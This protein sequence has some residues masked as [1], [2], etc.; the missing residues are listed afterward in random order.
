MKALL[1]LV[2]LST[3][4][5]PHQAVHMRYSE[6]GQMTFRTLPINWTFACDFPEET[7]PSVREGFVYWNK[8]L[9]REIFVE[10]KECGVAALIMSEL[11]RVLVTF[12]PGKNP[13]ND[14]TLAT[15]D[16]GL[17]D[18]IPRSAVLRY[19]GTWADYRMPHSLESVSRHEAGHVLG[20][21]HSDLD[22][23][24]M[25][26]TIDMPKYV[27]RAKQACKEE[28][29]EIKQIYGRKD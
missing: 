25:F 14:K 23:C 22:G 10:A 27:K 5:Y 6:A 15:A 9:D 21:D 13:Y 24:L 8:I 11:P 17:F 4:C 3:S 20:F 12:I 7:R 2:L 19:Y 26:P 28:I 18:G 29:K 16:I 1:L